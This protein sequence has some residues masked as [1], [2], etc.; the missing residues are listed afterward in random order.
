MKYA[1]TAMKHKSEE[2]DS[3]VASFFFHGRGLPI[4]RN[5]T[6][7]FRSLLNQIL[8][9][10]PEVLQKFSG[11]HQEHIQER[12]KRWEWGGSELRDFF[13]S[14]LPAASK[15]RPIVIFVD[16]LDEAFDEPG[17]PMDS[18]LAHFFVRL[19]TEVEKHDGRLK[20]CF[21]SRHYPGVI[22]MDLGN[23]RSISVDDENDDDIRSAVSDR[24][25]NVDLP[26]DRRQILEQEIV[27]RA[28]GIFQWAMLVTRDVFQ[29]CRARENFSVICQ[30]IKKTPYSL[31]SLYADILKD[32]R[33]KN[34][35]QSLKLL[36][37]VC[38]A[39]RPLS[40]LE[41]QHALA[42]DADM[43]HIKVKHYMSDDKR[44]PEDVKYMRDIIGKLSSGL[45]EVVKHNNT[46]RAQFIHQAVR[47]YLLKEGLDLLA[48]CT[49]SKKA[50]VMAGAKAEIS[51]KVRG[52]FQ[53]SRS[54]IKYLNLK[55]MRKHVQY[56]PAPDELFT[57]AR[58]FP[59]AAYALSSM[60]THLRDLDAS[61]ADQSDL[62]S[63]FCFPNG[64][65]R[66]LATWCALAER[67]DVPRRTLPVRE[68]TRLVHLLAECGVASA[69]R[70]VLVRMKDSDQLEGIINAKDAIG[71]TPV[72][73]AALEGHVDVVRLLVDAAPK[74]FALDDPDAQGNTPL[75]HAAEWGRV[76]VVKM[77]LETGQ[78]DVNARNKWK[79][80]AI[81]KASVSGHVKVVEVLLESGAE[82]SSPFF[83][84]S[85]P[86]A[87]ARRNGKEEVVKMLREVGA[88][89]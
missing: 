33:S 73:Y 77:L 4:Q 63:L 57:A 8:P 50:P 25:K 15:A 29:K 41:L 44:F 38:F 36:Q 79:Q 6:G 12:G 32:T 55:D 72:A 1:W 71:M 75:I 58:K 76:E 83:M 9:Q 31:H 28:N 74:G 13:I 51:P 43:E 35:A 18:E 65:Q 26:D 53:I 56:S 69:L 86:L 27:S 68:G 16:A 39:E 70:K 62:L 85:S 34:Q 66:I 14:N 48:P 17:R 60:K 49:D 5:Q 7:L 42:L 2:S 82:H 89:E 78:V 88:L 19:M 3:V 47:D 22:N 67:L 59:L 46:M 24:L 64:D 81:W 61:G 20:I 84:H 11:L 37:W 54:G 23:A 21:S 52:L 80:T 87:E 30:S 10:F 45:V 40:T